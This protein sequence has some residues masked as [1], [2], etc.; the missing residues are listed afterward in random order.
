MNTLCFKHD[1]FLLT[2]ISHGLN[3]QN[4]AFS[5]TKIEED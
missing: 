4:G 3:L 5:G 2:A 1:T